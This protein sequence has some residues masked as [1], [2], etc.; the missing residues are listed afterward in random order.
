[1]AKKTGKKEYEKLKRAAYE[2]IVVQDCT[3]GETAEM[4]GVSE[5]TVSEWAR[6]GGWRELRRAR[7]SAASTANSNL[8]SII[9]LLSEQ[10][11]RIE[12]EIHE[13]QSAG[14]KEEELE[15]RK[16]ANIISD[17]LVKI[18][19]TLKDNDRSNGIT[20]GVYIDIMDDIFNNLRIFDR[21]L[22]DRTLDFQSALI[23]K[24]TIELG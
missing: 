10:R 21:E 24:K 11:L 13:A 16:K 23:Q 17:D 12:Q 8:K 4:I 14:N 1:M 7:Q 22:Y 5:K 2:Y 6:T 19:K 3:Q 20:L 9:S 18:N 15:L